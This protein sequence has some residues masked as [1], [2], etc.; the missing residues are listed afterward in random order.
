MRKKD[1]EKHEDDKYLYLLYE[2]KDKDYW[3]KYWR[4]ITFGWMNFIVLVLV[5]LFLLLVEFFKWLQ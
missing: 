2:K 5:I 3:K 1:E 4:N